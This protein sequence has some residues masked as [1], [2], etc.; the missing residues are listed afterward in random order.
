MKTPL[1]KPNLLIK[2][3]IVLAAAVLTAASLLVPV[4][5]AAD[6]LMPDGPDGRQ[7]FDRDPAAPGSLTR[8]FMTYGKD[9]DNNE[10]P[11]KTLRITNNT[12]HTVFPIMRDPNA[13]TLQENSPVGLYDPYDPAHKEYRGYIGYED[14]GKYYFGLKKGE[15]IIVRLPLVFWNGAR[16]GIG[17]DAKYL[18]PTVLPNPLGYDPN[19][20]R[21]ITTACGNLRCPGDP[22]G[23]VMWY[24]A[25]ESRA[26][27]DDSEDQLA[28]WTIRDHVYLVN[29]DITR[30]TSNKIPDNQ[31]VT[32]INYDVSNV[33]NL[34]LPLAMAAN[35]VWVVPQ[36]NC[37]KPEP[38]RTCWKP[39]TDP[40]VY[41]WVGADTTNG[42]LQTQIRA[43]T[44]DNNR[45]L[46]KYFD[47]DKGWPFYN[48]PNPPNAPQ[49]IPS[50]A[51]V[52]AQS[53]LRNVD[54]SYKTGTWQTDKFMLSS[55]GGESKAATIGW[56]GGTPDPPNQD[57]LHLNYHDAGER[58][59]IAFL[60]EGYL[61]EGRPPCKPN[62]SPCERLP[63]PI[64]D[65]TTL[66]K[67][68]DRA[69]GEV[70]LSKKLVA[71]SEACS[72][73]FSRPVDDYASDAMIRLW[74]SWAQYYL[75]HWKDHTPGAPT[76]PTP[77]VGSLDENTGTLRFNIIHPELVKGMAVTG[78]GLDNAQTEDGIHQGNALILEIAGDQKSVILSQVA[79]KTSTN[80]TFTIY[81][82][83]PFCTGGDA[84]GCLLWA[85]TAKGDP[86]YPLIGD[87]FVFRNEPDW[88]NPYNFS[89][90]VYMI[91]AS[92]NQI[93]HP[94][95]DSVSK[96]MQDIVGANMGYIFNNEAKKSFDAQEI[97]AMIR[98]MIKSVLRGVTDFTQFPDEIIDNKHTRWYPDPAERRGNQMF[99][100]FNLDPFVWFVHVKLGFSG[101]GFSVDD[102]TADVG[103][104][105]ASELQISVTEKGGLKNTDPWTIQAPYGPVKNV[106]LPYSGPKSSTNGAT[107]YQDIKEVSGPPEP[108]TITAPAGRLLSNGDTVRITDVP[109][110]AGT[111]AN[112]DRK[113]G[114]LTR[115]SFGLFDVD[116]GKIPILSSGA[117]NK[118]CGRWSYPLHPYTNSGADPKKVFYRVTGDDALGTFLGTFVSV[119][120]VD[121]NKKKGNR[122]RVWRLG[123]LDVGQLLLDD[124]LTDADG[125]PL[126][127]G[128]YNFTFFGT[129]EPPT[130]LGGQPPLSLGSIR[131]DI[132]NE[133]DRIWERLRQLEKQNSDP[134]ESARKS[135]WLKMRIAVLRGRLQYPTDEVL[136]QLEQTVEAQ[137]S[138]GRKKYQNF[139][140]QLNTR[141]AELGAGG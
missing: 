108:I 5:Q 76:Q 101:Y 122:F 106:S 23:V 51:N 96:F 113:I 64:Q 71:S 46:G 25:E 38:N 80:A 20:Q 99:N 136:E 109:A 111:N 50:G 52:F 12:D 41:G 102:D 13:S 134:K 135:R 89:Q 21:S 15:S 100:V 9:S 95:N 130:G 65:G 72:F 120:G 62:T 11:V 63:N 8:Q 127:A 60:Q 26:P 125:T 88:H 69:T 47:G 128:T 110:P 116:T 24:R 105:G 138:L 32:L 31:L 22:N 14:G 86:G 4:A 28:E 137:N 37:D 2:P 61:V 34:F 30:R 126:P 131:E 19:S 33:D 84:T 139:L 57:I 53:P 35:D 6:P 83:Q 114:N 132:H 45:L 98:D 42:F 68:I 91:M 40:D 85:P 48:I 140:D 104:G 129:A 29:K 44:A 1:L 81:P 133:L 74:Y 94:N 103:A 59:K 7:P 10:I 54:S 87:K 92:M 121:R 58:E 93:G 78:P 66:L 112:G 27:K 124:D 39:G 36:G 43:F 107:I 67:I 70:Q 97:I 3:S 115:N 55:G 123:P 73:T 56:A 18:T 141:L 117:C 118:G 49:K 17:T 119:N 90:Q 16:I 77:I 82:P 79:N 75:A